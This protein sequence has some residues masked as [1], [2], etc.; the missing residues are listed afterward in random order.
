MELIP[1]REAAARLRLSV[2]T[3]RRLRRLEQ[4][5]AWVRLARR[6]YYPQDALETWLVATTCTP[7][8]STTQTKEGSVAYA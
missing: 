6:I 8:A 3:L 1:E 7:S 5:P 2:F 4:G